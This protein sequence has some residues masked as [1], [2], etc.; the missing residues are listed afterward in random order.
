MHSTLFIAALSTFALVH[1]Q[2]P[3]P[4]PGTTGE[5]GPAEEV[6]GNPPGVTYQAILP[7]S[8]KSTIRGYVAGTSSPDGKGVD[9][10]VNIFGLPD[11]SLGPFRKLIMSQVKEISLTMLAIRT[12][13]HI[14]D[15]PVPTDGNC[16]GTKAHLDPYIRGQK[17]PCDPEDPASC[18]VGDLS[19]KHGNITRNPFQV[20]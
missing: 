10:N 11:S 3:T 8:K 19:G 18:E 20:T 13:Y 1:A 4:I 16:T 15:Q 7:D 5:L 9:F 12:V 6:E 14:H 2:S 17:I